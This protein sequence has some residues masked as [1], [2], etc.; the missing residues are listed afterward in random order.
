[1]DFFLNPPIIILTSY[2]FSQLAD[3]CSYSTQQEGTAGWNTITSMRRHYRQLQLSPP[4][5]APGRAIGGGIIIVGGAAGHI[6]NNYIAHNQTGAGWGG[7]IAIWD[8]NGIISGNLIAH[9]TVPN[10]GGG[11]LQ[12]F[13]ASSIVNIRRNTFE[14]N[15]ASGAAGIGIGDGSGVIQNNIVRDNTA[16]DGT[17]G[18]KVHTTGNIE[19]RENWITSNYGTIDETF[20]VMNQAWQVQLPMV[21]G[22]P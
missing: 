14:F 8:A 7:G 5:L 16:V 6:E 13:G 9:N 20:V 18:I 12:V 22:P 17:G 2:F 10:H 19:I 15:H 11:G 21:L 1:M 3:L 4:I